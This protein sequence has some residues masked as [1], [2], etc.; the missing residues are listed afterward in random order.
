MVNPLWLKTFITLVEQ[1]HFTRTAGL[2][3]MTQPGVSQH[4][5]KLEAYYQATL[6]NRNEKGFELTP[7]GEKV[8]RFARNLVASEEQLKESLKE[9]NPYEGICRL[10]SPGALA[11]RLYPQLCALQQQYPQLLMQYEVAPNHRISSD[12]LS[13]TIDIGLIT[14]QS[15]EPELI[16]CP[17]DQERL[18]LVVPA[19]FRHAGYRE[20]CQLGV[21]MHPDASHHISSVLRSNYAQFRHLSEL[22]V[23]GAVNQ[24]NLIL[25][26]VAAGNGFTVLP[27]SMVEAFHQQQAISILNMTTAVYETIYLAHKRHRLLASR[28]RFILN[29]LFPNQL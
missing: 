24:I 28:Y 10:S 20:L 15:D 19:H 16:T 9:D 1:K 25:E 12:L 21:I 26:P 22:P 5:R 8:L 27:E 6:I 7:E 13:N 2:L 11:M 29:A 17:I 18:L 4:I 14:H 23:K 3:H